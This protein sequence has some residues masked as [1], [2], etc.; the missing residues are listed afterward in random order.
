M[1]P[2][3]GARETYYSARDIP[4]DVGGD[5]GSLRSL[6]HQGSAMGVDGVGMV[7][8]AAAKRAGVDVSVRRRLQDIKEEGGKLG[9][10]LTQV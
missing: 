5:T 4:V 3:L 10:E 7:G 8:G 1:L 9:V 6:E 2:T